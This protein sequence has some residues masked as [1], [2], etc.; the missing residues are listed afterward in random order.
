MPLRATYD[1]VFK[2]KV[3]EGIFDLSGTDISE[4]QQLSKHS[5][6]YLKGEVRAPTLDEL[7]QNEQEYEDLLCTVE[8]QKEL[9]EH[10]CIDEFAES[11]IACSNRITDQ[12]G[13]MYDP[14]ANNC[15]KTRAKFGYCMFGNIFNRTAKYY[16]PLQFRG[17]ADCN[18]KYGRVHEG[19]HP[20]C[21][22]KEC[23]LEE[24]ILMA[25]D[26]ERDKFRKSLD[27]TGDVSIAANIQEFAK[28]NHGMWTAWFMQNFL[29]P[30]FISKDYDQW[31]VPVEHWQEVHG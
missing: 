20:K 15:V 3:D 29:N 30:G 7:P 8:T 28:T 31:H 18:K 12:D 19:P 27:R 22:L 16:C 6:I 13:R 25:N 5:D 26:Q 1:D 23:R 14:D 17:M 4:I 21:A 10:I 2:R 11:I 24:C 9:N